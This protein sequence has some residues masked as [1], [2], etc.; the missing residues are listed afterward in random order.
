MVASVLVAAAVCPHPPLL[1]P[2]LA[3]GGAPD[4][5]KVRAA[6]DAAVAGLL[7]ERPDE[8]VVVGADPEG[9]TYPATA[10]ASM[11]PY[12]VD[13][14]VGGPE[15]ELPLALAIGAW[16]LD[17]ADLSSPVS[18]AGIAP[19]APM[20]RCRALGR[21][22]A[23]ATDRVALLVMADGSARRT[24]RSPGRHDERGEPFDASV[25]AALSSGDVAALVA[26]DPTLASALMVEGRA[27]WQVLAGAAEPASGPT[28]VIDA[29]VLFDRAPYG[30]GYVVAT[31]R[32]R[33]E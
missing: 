20:S 9:G 21:A 2:Q 1:V 33:T 12:G 31:W 7:A 13:L 22:L 18:F 19:D 28:P 4:L 6:C 10:G 32:Y 3:A 5:D 16:L 30:V 29:R 24:A 17:R 14:R 23:A 25:T 8:I 27:A 26:L 11:Q 15:G